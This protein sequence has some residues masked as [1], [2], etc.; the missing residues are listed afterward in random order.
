[1]KRWD[2]CS[3][4]PWYIFSLTSL[5]RFNL[6]KGTGA[7]PVVSR[8]FLCCSLS[9]SRVSHKPSLV[10]CGSSIRTGWVFSTFSRRWEDTLSPHYTCWRTPKFCTRENRPPS[11]P[12]TYPTEEVRRLKVSTNPAVTPEPSLCVFHV[13]WGCRSWPPFCHCRR[14]GEDRK[15]DG[16]IHKVSTKNHNGRYSHFSQSTKKCDLLIKMCSLLL[17]YN[18]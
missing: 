6:A 3:M 4:K 12:S 7:Y 9:F 1:M 18:R 17:I 5:S 10:C 15:Y 11:T 8:T 16:G 14:W 2:V 13:L